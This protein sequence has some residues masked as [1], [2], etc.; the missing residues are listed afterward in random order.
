MNQLIQILNLSS[1]WPDINDNTCTTSGVC[2]RLMIDQ[3]R[4]DDFT[5]TIHPQT[6][7]QP[8]KYPKGPHIL[9]TTI[10][11]QRPDEP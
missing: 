3:M 8:T 2:E 1:E 5:K 9:Q 7:L 4:E 6:T 10:S 11:S